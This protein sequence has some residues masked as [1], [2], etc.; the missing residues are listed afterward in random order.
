MPTPVYITQTQED[1]HSLLSDQIFDM[2]LNTT[3]PTPTPTP[4]STFSPT[5]IP[6]FKSK[7]APLHNTGLLLS[8]SNYLPEAVGSTFLTIPDGATPAPGVWDR[9]S[10]QYYYENTCNTNPQYLLVMAYGIINPETGFPFAYDEEPFTSYHKKNELKVGNNHLRGEVIQRARLDSNWVGVRWGNNVV[11][12]SGSWSKQKCFEWLSNNP[13]QNEQDYQYIVDTVIK[14][15]NFVSLSNQ[16]QR[17][18]LQNNLSPV[19]AISVNSPASVVS[20][21]CRLT[22]SSNSR[23]RVKSSSAMKR[24]GLMDPATFK[25]VLKH[26]KEYFVQDKGIQILDPVTITRTKKWNTF[27]TAAT[28][29]KNKQKK[30]KFVWEKKA[31]AVEKARV[32]FID[33][34]H[35]LTT[36]MLWSDTVEK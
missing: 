8:T 27:W 26:Q 18:S 4:T 11:P 12:K 2:K 33:R 23:Y 7:P 14:L 21:P 1:D 28:K 34:I 9:Y 36:P 31:Q 19:Q 29:A 16:E 13:I 17:T 15:I 25:L 35:D 32:D 22:E 10:A 6:A 24:T 20:R 30:V 5:P 3:P